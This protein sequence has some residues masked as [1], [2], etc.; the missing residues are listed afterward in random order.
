MNKIKRGVSLLLCSLLFGSAVTLGNVADV[1]A[2]K[3][4]KT[5]TKQT[6]NNTKTKKKVSDDQTSGKTGRN[7]EN[8][9]G[10]GAQ[11]DIAESKVTFFVLPVYTQGTT[12][13]SIDRDIGIGQIMDVGFTD[14]NF[15]VA[16]YDSLFE[17]GWMGTPGQS[18]KEVL[19]SFTG[20]IKADGYARKVTYIASA[21]MATFIPSF[22]IKDISKEFNTQEELQEQIKWY[23]EERPDI[24]G[25]DQIYIETKIGSILKRLPE[26]D[27]QIHSI[28][29]GWRLERLGKP[30]LAILRLAVYEITNDANIPTGVA[31]NEAVE[32]AKIYC[33]EEAPR[34]VNGVLAKLA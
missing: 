27:E 30:E 23:F 2:G 33:S 3:Q 6:I 9:A 26:I 20:M 14:R 16:V 28:C 31:I 34:F 7:E 8:K 19:G 12:A 13:I 10:E 11:T 1:Q 24:E 18:V 22:E 4:I 32:L 17:A 5:E 29:E 15:A 21:Q 25:K